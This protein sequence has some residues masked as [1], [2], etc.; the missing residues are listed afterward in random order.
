MVYLPS[1]EAVVALIFTLSV[2]SCPFL[3]SYRSIL[4]PDKLPSLSFEEVRS[5][6]HIF[7]R[8]HSGGL[9]LSHRHK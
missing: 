2:H 4:G 7:F 3:F 9:K 6:F 8:G 5:L 1:A